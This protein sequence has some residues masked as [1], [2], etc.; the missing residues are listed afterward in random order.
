MNKESLFNNLQIQN[1]YKHYTWLINLPLQIKRIANFGCSS[2]VKPFAFL[3]ILDA[4]E[5]MVVDFAEEAIKDLCEEIEIVTNRCPESLQGRNITPICRD[6]THSLPELPDLY[7]DLAYCEDVLYTLPLQGGAKKLE[8]AIN[9]MIRVIKP[10]GLLIAVEPKFGVTF[11]T[12]EDKT[13]GIHLSTGIPI[14]EPI[15]MSEI[16]LSKNLKKLEIS[17]CPAYT[18][19]YQ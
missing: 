7:F 15:D 6:M 8:Q 10:N 1:R 12:E 3:W 18:Y 19:C 9:Q 4:K 14:T 5:V 11:Q 13:L 16:F 2:C 17:K